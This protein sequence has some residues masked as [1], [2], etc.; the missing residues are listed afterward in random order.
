MVSATRGTEGGCRAR[1][2]SSHWFTSCT[3]H[4]QILLHPAPSSLLLGHLQHC[5]GLHGNHHG[6]CEVRQLLTSYH[7]STLQLKLQEM[8]YSFIY[9]DDALRSNFCKSWSDLANK[10]FAALAPFKVVRLYFNA[11]AMCKFLI[12]RCEYSSSIVRRQINKLQNRNGT[13][14][15][16]CY[17][18]DL[19]FAFCRRIVNNWF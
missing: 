1:R 7:Y 9:N 14:I 8:K 13:S 11:S 3:R 15:Q 16:V 17:F 12:R 5:L 19:Q 6:N 2:G 18:Q 10:C 4:H